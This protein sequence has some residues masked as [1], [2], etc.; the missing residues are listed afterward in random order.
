MSRRNEPIRILHV[1]PDLAEGGL[2]QGVVRL[3]NS[4]PT[5][6]FQ[7]EVCCL[8]ASGS[9]GDQL[10]PSLPVHELHA[11]WHDPRTAIRLT[12]T[13]RRFQPDIVH[14]R[15][16][17]TW[18]DAVLAG[19]LARQA[20]LIFSQHGWDFD[21]PASRA[22]AW[23]CRRLARRTDAVCSVSAHAADLF[24]AETGLDPRRFQILPNGVDTNRFAPRPDSA[25]LRRQLGIDSNAFVIGSVGRL[26]PIKDYGLL[27]RAVAAL[28][29]KQG[30][31]CQLLLVGE[32]SQ[33]QNLGLLARNLGI[34]HLVRFVGWRDDVER[35][36][37]TMDVFALTSRREGMNNA[38]LE[39]M[40]SAIPIVATAVGGNPEVIQDGLQGLLIP[41]GDRDAL[42]AALARLAHDQPRRRWLG[43]QARLH[44]VRSFSFERT[45]RRYADLYRR[46]AA[47]PFSQ[48][49]MTMTAPEF[50]PEMAVA[51][52]PAT[53]RSPQ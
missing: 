47:R 24:A 10:A 26:E 13:I 44:V 31:Q 51:P 16:W 3:I 36:L 6:E 48:A 22:R 38:V 18:P 34:D 37:A 42:V 14:A 21:A 20:R 19:I 49:A 53:A 35:I 2:Q 7:H 45:L 32:G 4:L 52:C 41:P 25:D 5:D 8:H 27:L 15:N 9:T 1:V 23:V 29:A 39:A 50:T 28:V 43:A 17:S 40:A 33:R 12:R 46:M 11:G 30:T